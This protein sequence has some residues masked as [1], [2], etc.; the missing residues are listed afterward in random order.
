MS[1]LRT[2]MAA[3][4]HDVDERRELKTRRRPPNRREGAAAAA[5]VAKL[6]QRL[7]E[8]HAARPYR[9]VV[10]QLS[11]GAT[12]EYHAGLVAGLG[13][14]ARPKVACVC[15]EAR[16]SPVWQLWVPAFCDRAYVRELRLR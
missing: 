7:A 16:P 3:L 10:V 8:S 1:G 2:G 4:G 13:G 11:S 5:E 9:M 14:K 6:R 12:N 15:T